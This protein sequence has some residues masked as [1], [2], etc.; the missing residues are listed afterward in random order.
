MRHTKLFI[1][2][3][4]AFASL[5]L[6]ACDGDDETG[7]GGSDPSGT[8]ASGGTGGTGGTGGAGGAGGGMQADI[9]EQLQALPGVESVAVTRLE[10]LLLGPNGEVDQG[11]LPI[12]PLEIA[13]LDSDPSF[14]ENGRIRFDLRGGR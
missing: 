9:F 5:S 7:S 14:P 13:R 1:P 12:G 4:L 10:R 6:G 11:F 8:G 2:L 3:M